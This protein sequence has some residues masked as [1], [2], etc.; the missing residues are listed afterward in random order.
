MSAQNQNSTLKTEKPKMVE[1]KTLLAWQSPA[2]PF[3]K[4]DREYFTTIGAIVFLLAVILLFLKEWLLIA[5]MIALM[6]VAYILASVPPEEVEHKITTRG[7]MTGR[8]HYNWDDLAKFWFSERWKQAI[9]H[10][11]TKLRFP[12]QLII[13]LGETDKEEIK[14][15]LGKYLTFDQPEPTWMDNAAGWL[16]KKVPLEKTS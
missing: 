2:R 6:F 15:L 7:I 16:A 10:V 11:E 14:K 3:K 12:G 8:R 4:R 13:L 1:L 9:L 5:V